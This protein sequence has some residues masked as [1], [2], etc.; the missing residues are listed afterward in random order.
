MTATCGPIFKL[1][2]KDQGCVWIEDFH[3]YFDNIEEYFLGPPIVSPPVEGRPLIMYLTV[4]EDSMGC[5]LGQQDE[6]GRK[7]HAIY[8]PSKKFI[9]YESWYSMLEKTCY[10]LAWGAKRLRQYMINHTTWL[11]SKMDPIKYIFEKHSLT[12]RIARWQMLLSEYD[13]E[14]KFLDED[15]MYL[16]AKHC[17]EP[18]SEKGPEPRSRWSLIFD[19]VVNA[20]GN[21]IGEI[22]ITPHVIISLLLQDCCLTV[23]TTWKNMKLTSW[24]LKKPLI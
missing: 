21:G 20:Y 10:A 3:K 9:D 17:D 7:E 12:G 2:H 11:I 5:V 24:V 23:R 14:F 13:I 1:F 18:L 19:G 15:V 8:Y 22:T 6:T 4:L 16:K